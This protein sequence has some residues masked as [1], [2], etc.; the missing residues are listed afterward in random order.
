MSVQDPS[1]STDEP[2]DRNDTLQQT[3]V[4]DELP[5]DGFFG[6]D[7]MPDMSMH[8]LSDMNWVS[9]SFD[10]DDFNMSNDVMQH[11]TTWTTEVQDQSVIQQHPPTTE[12]LA[13]PDSAVEPNNVA[14]EHNQDGTY[15][16]DDTGSR[17]PRNRHPIDLSSPQ[18]WTARS[19][20]SA[21]SP[22]RF[23]EPASFEFPVEEIYIHEEV[24][25]GSS[26]EY[27]DDDQYSEISGSFQALCRTATYSSEPA[28]IGSSL[29]SIVSLNSCLRVYRHQFDPK[30]LPIVHNGMPIRGRLSWMVK[31]AM[32]AT[33][34]QY[35]QDADPET[36]IALHELLRRILRQHEATPLLDDNLPDMI[37]RTQAR[38]L[39]Y[40]FCAYSG[41]RRLEKH[42]TSILDALR[43]DH[44]RLYRA[45][46]A[47]PTNH[48]TENRNELEVSTTWLVQESARRTCHAIWLIDCQ[49]YY[50]FSISPHLLL[51]FSNLALPCKESSWSAPQPSQPTNVPNLDRAL[52]ILYLEKR[53]L[54]NVGDFARVLLIHAIYAQTWTVTRSLTSPLSRWTPSAGRDDASSIDT[55]KPWLPT[56]PLFSHWRNA[57]CDAFDVLH[58][59]ANSDIAQSGTENTTVLNL[60]FGRI[61]LLTPFEDIRSLANMLTNT[62][63][64]PTPSTSKED[65]E[66][67]IT[68]WVNEDQFK[69]RLAMI[70]CGVF[71]WHVRR[72]ST[73]AWYE[74]ADVWMATLTVWAYARYGSFPTRQRQDEDL[75][76]AESIRLDRPTDDELVQL[77]V[78]KGR[79]MR[80]TIAGV[81]D[82]NC[83]MGAG[84]MLREGVRVLEK[85]GGWGTAGY[86]ERLR[87]LGEATG[88]NEGVLRDKITFLRS[89]A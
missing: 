31:L 15:Y 17:R 23:A 89:S 65:L 9:P 40:L 59:L 55:S 22:A 77:F 46:E 66:A 8:M 16:L 30:V 85:L 83:R 54:P 76:E 52:L 41:S 68:K 81:G 58:W 5:Q 21:E 88:V 71:F 10:L 29:P 53:L 73:G 60:H 42:R 27:I 12:T 79:S 32:A 35:V 3:I 4:I 61:V 74:G 1:T 7:L 84:R 86:R 44:Q 34:S 43:R 64:H 25:S 56:V 13:V 38:L 80:A 63:A 75:G 70:H 50:H 14:Q 18:A 2:D 69:A 82:V 26:A 87:T 28:Y 6:Q 19:I 67:R 57:A 78:K 49:A 39:N 36:S 33:G 20:P 62:S 72:Y 47:D 24:A 11:E 51:N 48:A 37:C 45:C